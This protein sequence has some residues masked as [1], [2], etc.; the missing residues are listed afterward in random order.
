[1]GADRGGLTA[2]MDRSGPLGPREVRP[3]FFSRSPT[4]TNRCVLIH[5][6]PSVDQP[7]MAQRGAGCSRIC[8]SG[9]ARTPATL[10]EPQST[11]PSR[12]ILLGVVVCSVAATL[13]NPYGWGLWQF[14]ASTV[15]LGRADVIEWQPLWSANRVDWIPWLAM[16]LGVSAMI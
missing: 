3:R 15:R 6:R 2:D 13:I 16:T 8:Q 4:S 1:M 9:N 14:L 7:R 12:P 10:I 5:A 11:S